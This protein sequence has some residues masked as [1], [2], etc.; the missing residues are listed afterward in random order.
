MY[1][2]IIISILG[3]LLFISCQTKKSNSLKTSPSV[4]KSNLEEL[5]MIPLFVIN[6]KRM[7]PITIIDY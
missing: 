1:Q 5:T 6:H 4:E 3:L 2:F 7:Y